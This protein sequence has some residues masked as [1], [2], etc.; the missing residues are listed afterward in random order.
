MLMMTEHPAANIEFTEPGR[1]GG[2]LQL[3]LCCALG[4]AA[5]DECCN[6]EQ[7]W[8]RRD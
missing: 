3:Q 2:R 8:L 7:L 6:V 4:S 1:P 5:Q